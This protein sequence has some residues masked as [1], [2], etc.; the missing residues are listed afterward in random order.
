[1]WRSHLEFLFVRSIHF[2]A[3]CPL[4][5]AASRHHPPTP[6]QLLPCPTFIFIYSLL[7]TK[8]EIC[9]SQ[10]TFQKTVLYLKS[11]LQFFSG[12]GSALEAGT[13]PVR[14]PMESLSLGFYIDLILPAALGPWGRLSLELKRVPGMFLG[15]KAAG[16]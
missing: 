10:D 5:S 4:P 12:S 8:A 1:M 15:V 13:S 11:V 7:F 14:F 3:P 2:A 6:P 9:R 16:A